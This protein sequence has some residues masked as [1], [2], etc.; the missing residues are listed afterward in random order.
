MVGGGG[1]VK[2]LISVINL[3]VSTAQGGNR[4]VQ[5]SSVGGGQGVLVWLGG[6]GGL[7]KSSSVSSR[8]SRRGPA[9][10]STGPTQQ[11]CL[12]VRDK[13]RGGLAGVCV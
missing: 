6:G 10:D 13:P 12:G 9:Q 5:H 3:Q 4:Q 7:F 11:L 2:V 8:S 1:A